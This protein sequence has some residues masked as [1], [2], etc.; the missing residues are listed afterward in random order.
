AV[1]LEGGNDLRLWDAEK[2]D[3]PRLHQ[4]ARWTGEVAAGDDTEESGGR[5]GAPHRHQLATVVACLVLGVPFAAAP[6]ALEE[7]DGDA[8]PVVRAV[9]LH[10]EVIIDRVIILIL[11][12]NFLSRAG[13]TRAESI[14]QK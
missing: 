8:D 2:I 14:V 5:V 6:E 11:P 12:A 10:Y 9:Q 1:L 7:G 3:A 4:R 13:F